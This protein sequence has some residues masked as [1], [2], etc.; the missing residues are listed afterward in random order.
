MPKP[1]S[2]VPRWEAKAVVEVRI[3]MDGQVWLWHQGRAWPCVETQPVQAQA[4]PTAKKTAEPALPR[5]PAA[6]HP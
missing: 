4:K 6:N 3:D 1:G 5:K 2:G